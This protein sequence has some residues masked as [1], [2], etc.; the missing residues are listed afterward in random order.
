MSCPFITT[1]P[2][3]AHTP[4][5]LLRGVM[6]RRS[7][8]AVEEQLQLPPCVREDERVT[9][10]RVER[11]F[12]ESLRKDFGQVRSSHLPQHACFCGLRKGRVGGSAGYACLWLCSKCGCA[13]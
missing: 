9:L 3:H 4:R 10:S 2:L 11:A 8:A 1:H 6:L 12:Y 7:K 13:V 5:A